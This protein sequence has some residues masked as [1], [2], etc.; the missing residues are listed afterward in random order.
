MGREEVYILPSVPCGKPFLLQ[1]LKM[2]L[3][4]A[5]YLFRLDFEVHVLRRFLFCKRSVEED[6]V[7]LEGCI[8]TEVRIE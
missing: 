1:A 4:E 6:L 7:K 8:E 5:L 3:S 2:R